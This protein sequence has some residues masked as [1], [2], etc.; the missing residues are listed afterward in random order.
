M[1]EEQ[2]EDK[3]LELIKL[4]DGEY[5]EKVLDTFLH[6]PFASTLGIL[7]IMLIL[8][9]VYFLT[10]NDV[11]KQLSIAIPFVALVVAF[12]G[13]FNH[14]F[15]ET[16][17]ERNY[18]RIGKKTNDDQKPLLKEL[19]KMKAK[20]KEFNLEQIYHMNEDMFTKDKLLEKLYE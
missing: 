12:L 4:V 5:Q 2:T 7:L 15:E 19:I 1:N 8:I 16:L 6:S 9:D 11:G 20:N 18:D 10:I 13:I 3:I 17:I 14:S